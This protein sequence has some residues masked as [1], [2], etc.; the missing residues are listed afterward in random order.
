MLLKVCGTPVVNVRAVARTAHFEQSAAHCALYGVQRL[1][2]CNCST[3]HSQAERVTE[4][5]TRAARCD[6]DSLTVGLIG[7]E[8][9]SVGKLLSYAATQPAQTQQR[10]R[11]QLHGTT[12]PV[13]FCGERVW[14]AHKSHIRRG[15][16]VDQTVGSNQPVQ[17]TQPTLTP[18]TRSSQ[19]LHTPQPFTSSPLFNHHTRCTL[20]HCPQ[21]SHPSI[22]PSNLRLTRAALI[23]LASSRHGVSLL[24]L[25]AF[26]ALAL[27]SSVPLSSAQSVLNFCYYMQQDASPP[28]WNISVQ[29]SM[30][31]TGPVLTS[32]G[33]AVYTV[34]GITGVR[35]QGGTGASTVYITGLASNT[36][37]YDNTVSTQWPFLKGGTASS[38]PGTPGTAGGIGYTVSSPV[39]IPSP[40]PLTTSTINIVSHPINE[41]PLYSVSGPNNPSGQTGL[42]YFIFL[43]ASS[44]VPNCDPSTA[45]TYSFYYS[46]TPKYGALSA[47]TTNGDWSACVSANLTVLGPFAIPSYTGSG[48]NPT[49]VVTGATGS[50]Y[51]VAQRGQAGTTTQL[52]G[53]G[54]DDGGD[55]MIYGQGPIVSNA[56]ITFRYAAIPPVITAGGLE[57]GN[58]FKYLNVWS[59]SNSG[60]VINEANWNIGSVDQS[61]SLA[62][63]QPYGTNPIIDN[64]VC[65]LSILTQ[66]FSFCYYGEGVGGPSTWT[67]SMSGTI[68]AAPEVGGSGHWYVT[69][70]TGIRVQTGSAPSRTNVTGVAGITVDAS[71]SYG[72]LDN[73][74]SS[75]YPFLSSH[76]IGFQLSDKITQ[77]APVGGTAPAPTDTIYLINDP[78]CELGT[79]TTGQYSQGWSTFILYPASLNGAICGTPGTAGGLPTTTLNFG[80]LA[81]PRTGPAVTSNNNAAQP[82]YFSTAAAPS[83]KGCSSSFQ[84]SNT[85]SCPVWS[86]CATATLTAVGPLR[87]PGP[88]AA[89]NVSYAFAIYKATGFR[90]YYDVTGASQTNTITGMVFQDGADQTLYFGS[91]YVDDAG[92]TFALSDVPMLAF[93]DGEATSFLEPGQ[94]PTTYINLWSASQGGTTYGYTATEATYSTYPDNTA[95]IYFGVTTATTQYGVVLPVQ[96]PYVCPAATAPAYTILNFCIFVSAVPGLQLTGSAKAV[97]YS[98]QFIAQPASPTSSNWLVTGITGTRSTYATSPYGFGAAIPQTAFSTQTLSS[99]NSGDGNN[100]LGNNQL[101]QSYPILTGG[102]NMV[103]TDTVSALQQE[104]V[105]NNN[106]PSESLESWNNAD[107][108]YIVYTAQSDTSISACPPTNL[109]T[110]S[111]YYTAVPANASDDNNQAY[112]TNPSTGRQWSSCMTGLIQVI[113]PYTMPAANGGASRT[114]YVVL[115]ATGAR[116]FVDVNGTAW[117]TWLT[118]LNNGVGGGATADGADMLLFTTAPYVDN[119]GITFDLSGPPQWPTSV[120]N[121]ANLN[122]YDYINLWYQGLASGWNGPTEAVPTPTPYNYVSFSYSA[123][124][125]GSSSLYQ[126]P[127]G[128]NLNNI[129]LTF[130][131]GPTQNAGSNGGGGSSSSSN[132]DHTLSN[133]QVAGIAVGVTLAFIILIILAVLLTMACTSGRKSS[134]NY[135]TDNSKVVNNTPGHVQMEESRSTATV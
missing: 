7:T 84:N 130:G 57:S 39:T 82:A 83:G 28:A 42:S 87:L 16:T 105:I 8:T 15:V 62:Y 27:L 33:V 88:T 132:P 64:F 121:A 41:Q 2:L 24:S 68:L 95:Q 116:T 109:T 5:F 98:G 63:P 52:T 102:I 48:T 19:Y 20:T 97:S 4:C 56:G 94:T 92:I 114:A 29:G 59:T 69:S 111:F 43:S 60:Y 72:S 44:G 36:S 22:H 104:I 123:Y 58:T 90:Y 45:V 106:P 86:A 79:C 70:A 74:I 91:P 110:M 120:S 10:Q 13:S 1:Q 126:C 17:N 73:Q 131:T 93:P 81:T 37:L 35:T 14:S 113:G 32:A 80:Y 75:S 115:G 133:G 134:A 3:A 6:I 65:P 46:V 34:V 61:V 100:Q 129:P 135:S 21:Q 85:L 128:P 108:G 99:L 11:V 124:T 119:A 50:R 71:T 117:T 76:G 112:N 66:E 51:I 12:G 89:S 67:V 30:T 122:Q 9:R 53:V 96:A 31:V 18:H 103:V 40:T 107:T 127:Q 125:A 55:F 118:G 54:T 101:G 25:L 77:P 26:V 78:P 49:L 23:M 47:A 38:G